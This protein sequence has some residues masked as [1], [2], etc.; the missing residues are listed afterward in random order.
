MFVRC[1]HNKSPLSIFLRYFF[2]Q[3]K[4]CE[5]EW[6]IINKWEDN[7]ITS[8]VNIDSESTL[9]HSHKTSYYSYSIV[10]TVPPSEKNQ[11]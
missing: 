2:H 5:C 11:N 9:V 7:E 3:W 8:Q 6:L 4:V 10:Q 1:F